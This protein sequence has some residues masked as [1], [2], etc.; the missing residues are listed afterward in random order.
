MIR[1]LNEWFM[2]WIKSSEN[3]SQGDYLKEKNG[4]LVLAKRCISVEL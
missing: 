3:D 4:I 2:E 1:A